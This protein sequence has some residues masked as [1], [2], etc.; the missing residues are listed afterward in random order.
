MATDVR[1]HIAGT[2]EPKSAQQAKLGEREK[3]KTSLNMF[4]NDKLT[5]LFSEISRL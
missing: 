3:T 1:L 5:K 4:R 2:M